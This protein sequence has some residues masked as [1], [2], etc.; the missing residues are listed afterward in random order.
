MKR[1]LKRCKHNEQGGMATIIAIVIS[2]ILVLGLISYA[3]LSQVSGVRDTGDRALVEQNKLQ[4]LL[5][6]PNV[7]TGSTVKRMYNQ[8]G[9]TSVTLPAGSISSIKDGALFHMQKTLDASGEVVSVSFT[10]VDMSK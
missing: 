7:V 8:L 9:S 1:F 10:V 4:R 2:I 5:S 6:D 3:V